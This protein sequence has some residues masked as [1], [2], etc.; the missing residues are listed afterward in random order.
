MR[1]TCSGIA[2]HPW[3]VIF[4]PSVLLAVFAVAVAAIVPRRIGP[5]PF[6]VRLAGLAVVLGACLSLTKST[7]VKDSILLLI[8]ALIGPIVL[9]SALRRC[10]I[11]WEL[12][13][14]GFL[15]MTAALLIRADWVF[16]RDYGFPTGSA[17]Y[18]A[19]FADLGMNVPY[20][21]HYYG[22]TNPDMLGTFLLIPL[23]LSVFWGLAYDL[24][25]RARLLLFASASSC[26]FTEVLV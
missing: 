18:R 23:A 22:L 25:R 12:M 24:S 5:L 19:K 16:V 11:R 21:F 13:C 4:M 26:L 1:P 15:V 6:P 17:L 14:I 3:H 10:E 8:V 2:S 9:L 7:D 20:D